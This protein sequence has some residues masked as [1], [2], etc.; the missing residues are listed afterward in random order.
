MKMYR[1]SS[2]KDEHRTEKAHGFGNFDVCEFCGNTQVPLSSEEL[3]K[4]EFAKS[5]N[6][7]YYHQHKM[8]LCDR[9]VDKLN[10]LMNGKD[11]DEYW[12][13]EYAKKDRFPEFQYEKA[14]QITWNKNQRVTNENR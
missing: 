5:C 6:T 4:T 3:Y 7:K 12:E 10:S 1:T 2:F 8:I 13:P 11:V 9:C 14:M